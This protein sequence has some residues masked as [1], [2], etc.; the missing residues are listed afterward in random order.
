MKRT[1]TIQ[2]RTQRLSC[3]IGADHWQV[4]FPIMEVRLSKQIDSATAHSITE[5]Q[6]C[7]RRPDPYHA[8]QQITPCTLLV[9]G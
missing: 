4:G 8:S 5:T 7:D 6:A 9:I 1:R 2:G 3:T